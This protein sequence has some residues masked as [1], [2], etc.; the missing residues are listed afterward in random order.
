MNIKE[1]LSLVVSNN[2]VGVQQNLMRLGL[3][4]ANFV[5]NPVS[6]MQLFNQLSPDKV[7]SKQSAMQMLAATLDVPFQANGLRAMELN[8]AMMN[9][10]N[11]LRLLIASVL[12]PH[13][14]TQAVDKSCR[15]HSKK[16]GIPM[17]G[18]AIL[19]LA[20]FGAL[21]ILLVILLAFK[22]LLKT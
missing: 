13:L 4:D 5:A 16:E 2:P 15:C 17:M 18:K 12:R 8:Q 6:V 14:P 10:N 19:I 20:G 11:D 1:L 3:S 7:S 9:H 22:K 21:F